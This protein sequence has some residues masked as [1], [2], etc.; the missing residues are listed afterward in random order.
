MLA[1]KIIQELLYSID[2]GIIELWYNQ[3]T[4]ENEELFIEETS[5]ITEPPPPVPELSPEELSASTHN[6]RSNNICRFTIHS[7]DACFSLLSITSNNGYR[8]HKRYLYHFSLVGVSCSWSYD[9]DLN[10]PDVDAN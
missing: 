4:M 8:T 5:T 3:Q 9:D 10:C 7:S 6:H 1:T 2:K